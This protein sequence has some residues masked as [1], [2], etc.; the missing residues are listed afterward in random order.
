MTSIL[1]MLGVTNPTTEETNEA[2]DELHDVIKKIDVKGRW[3]FAIN[4][5]PTQLTTVSGTEVYTYAS[6]NLPPDGIASD[7]LSLER[8]EV[9]TSS[10]PDYQIDIVDFD[11]WKNSLL[12]KES[13]QPTICYLEKNAAFSSQKMYFAPIPNSALDIRYYYRRRIYDF[14]NNS[15]PDLPSQWLQYLKWATASGPLGAVHG[16]K[17]EKRL[18]WA[19]QATIEFKELTGSNAPEPDPTQVIATYF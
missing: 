15:N 12:R 7:I 11:G 14:E 4:A 1:R 18:T 5:T 3:F 9:W 19:R 6:D 10:K 16:L 8:V 2:I 13:G 17:E